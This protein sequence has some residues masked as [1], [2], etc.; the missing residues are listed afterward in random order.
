MSLNS[1]ASDPDGAPAPSPGTGSAAAPAV[2]HRY[3]QLEAF[4]GGPTVSARTQPNRARMT[5]GRFGT[6]ARRD[7]QLL[8]AVAIAIPVIAMEALTGSSPRPAAILAPLGFVL[9]QLGLIT[10]RPVPRWLPQLRLCLSLGFVVLANV[11]ID[12]TGTWPLNALEVPV[13]G[14]AAS[15]SG[16]G[17]L[18]I[19]G[20]GV[21][22][23]LVPLA[24]TGGDNEL[25][26][27][28]IAIAMAA[29]VVAIGSR[30]IVLTL[31]RSAD[32]QRRA[33]VRDRRR[34]RQLGALE[35]VGRLLARTGPTDDA[36]GRVMELLE[37]TFGYRYPSV[38]AWDGSML[39][40]GAQRNYRFPI[41]AFPID[42]G[43]MGRVARTRQPAFLPDARSDL[44]FQSADPAI[45][46]EISVP[47]LNDDELLGVL[48][49]ETDGAH[50]IDRDDFATMLIVGDRLA[51]ALALGRERQKLTERTELLDR[52]TTFAATLNA[53]LD[54]QTIHDHVA[55]GAAE[56]VSA[57]MVVVE[58][59]DPP[60][61]EFQA[62]AV[63]GGTTACWAPECSPERASAAVRSRSGER[64]STTTW[65]ERSFPVGRWRP[66]SPTCS[67]RWRSRSS[68][69]ARWRAPSPGFEMTRAAHSRSRSG[70]SRTSSAVASPW[71]SP[72]PRCIRPP[73][74]PPSRMA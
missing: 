59:L 64:S 65:S 56:V 37:R 23:S 11:A 34:A 31:E 28:A 1:L 32:R 15:L 19:A 71:R 57:D 29:I 6:R 25:H 17:A 70:R 38:Y 3:P 61:G 46:S 9:L 33:N 36:L 49:V 21:V 7:P 39:Q 30:S 62:M 26:R 55:V 24:A 66:R 4:L 73:R 18:A 12:Q 16:A 27:E 35:A 45:V 5:P 67:P 69:R 74:R 20:L 63:A 43:V 10:I 60:T 52:L 14:L 40:L 68:T 58:L 72:M 8:L 54:P 41:S 48:N 22:A 47:L 2:R 53:S 42:H 51:A 44:D 13:V 50:A